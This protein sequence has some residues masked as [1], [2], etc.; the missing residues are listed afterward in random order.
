MLNFPLTF[1]MKMN[2]SSWVAME[3][4]LPFAK[5]RVVPKQSLDW[6]VFGSTETLNW[7]RHRQILTLNS[8]YQMAGYI[9]IAKSQRSPREFMQHRPLWNQMQIVPMFLR[10]LHVWFIFQE[11]GAM[12]MEEKG[13]C[14]DVIKQSTGKGLM[15]DQDCFLHSQS[16]FSKHCDSKHCFLPPGQPTHS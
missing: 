12:Q 3:T 8:Y 14:A 1:D 7:N 10:K 5:G 9:L 13:T 15:R 6:P 4:N 11:D 16:A 2:C